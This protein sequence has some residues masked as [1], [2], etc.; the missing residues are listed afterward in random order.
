[1]PEPSYKLAAKYFFR[2]NLKYFTTDLFIRRFTFSLVYSRL[3]R[4]FGIGG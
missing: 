4:R 1:M 2:S 3:E